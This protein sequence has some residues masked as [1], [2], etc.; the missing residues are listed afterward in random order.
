MSKKLKLWNGRSLWHKG[1]HVY[2]C[3]HSQAHALEIVNKAL[4]IVRGWEDRPDINPINMS[5]IRDYWSAGCWGSPMDGIVHE[6]G[7]WHQDT[8]QSKP[9][10][11]YPKN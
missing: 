4:R 7:V 2:V 6:V 3:A 5:E 9:I 8:R 11:I 10:R 1:G